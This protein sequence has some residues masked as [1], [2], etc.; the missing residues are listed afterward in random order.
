VNSQ[1]Q[2]TLKQLTFKTFYHNQMT[3][4]GYDDLFVDRRVLVFS[5]TQFRTACSHD[6]IDSYISHYNSM[7][8]NGIDDV[9]AVDSSDLMIGPLIDKKTPLI[10]PLP[11]RD[12]KFVEALSWHFD[13]QKDLKNLARL[14]QY[15]IIINNGEPEKFWHNPFKENAPLTILKDEKYRYRNLSADIVLQY[16]IGNNK[17]D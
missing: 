12:M 10:K 1:F 15:V 2:Q 11:D 9:C 3:T 8:A 4:F 16:L 17:T 7:V 13:Y 6:H 14:W 5:V